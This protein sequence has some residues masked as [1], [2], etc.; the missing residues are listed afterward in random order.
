MPDRQWSSP[1]CSL[2][3]T[4]QQRGPRRVPARSSR[5]RQMG[6]ACWS[7]ESGEGGDSG[8]RSEKERLLPSHICADA[9]GFHFLSPLRIGDM[10]CNNTRIDRIWTPP[11]SRVPA[12]SIAPITGRLLQVTMGV[13]CEPRPPT[14]HS[15]RTRRGISRH[16]LRLMGAAESAIAVVANDTQIW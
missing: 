8:G 4:Q 2:T 7:S 5:T 15:R 1:S 6:K 13:R 3:Q 14:C 10:P 16:Y 9:G 12:S 11:A